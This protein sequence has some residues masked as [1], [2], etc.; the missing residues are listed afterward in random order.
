M[1]TVMCVCVSYTHVINLTSLKR[2]V[3]LQET[4]PPIAY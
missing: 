3:A 1:R 4:N 2:D